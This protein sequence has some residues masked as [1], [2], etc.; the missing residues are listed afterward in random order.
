[1]Q[2]V[3]CPVTVCGDVH[4]QFYDLLELFRVAGDS[5]QTNFLFL[6]DYVDRGFFS[7]ETVTLLV[8]LKVRFRNRIFLLRGNHES[9]QITQVGLVLFLSLLLNTKSSALPF[10]G[11]NRCTDSTT[12]ACINTEEALK[13]GRVSQIYSI[14]FPLRPLWKGAFFVLMAAYPQLFTHWIKLNVFN[15]IKK[16]RMRFFPLFLSIMPAFIPFLVW[17]IMHV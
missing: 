8:C 6:G 16:C 4:G 14:I 13:C 17:T 10:F 15:E 11:S 12:N 3:R 9:R 1:M 2:P 7:V 5:P